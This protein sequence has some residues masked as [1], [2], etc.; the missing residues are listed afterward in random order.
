MNLLLKQLFR[1]NPKVGDKVAVAVGFS[2]VP[3]EGIVSSVHKGYCWID[4]IY[5][6]RYCRSFTASFSYCH[7]IY[8]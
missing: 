2:N 3:Q 7:F 8:L 4:V 6:G 1:N 5:E